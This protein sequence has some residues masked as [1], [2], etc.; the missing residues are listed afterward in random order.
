[1]RDFRKAS[2]LED[3]VGAVAAVSF[4]ASD[5]SGSQHEIE[6]AVSAIVA[7]PEHQVVEHR[8]RL[9]QP[10]VLPSPREPHAR[11]LS[12]RQVVDLLSAQH[13]RTGIRVH[14]AADEIEE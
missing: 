14:H 9:E 12:N 5:V 11:A 4:P 2:P 13:D 1:M 6:K 10:D 8:E 3:D 7:W